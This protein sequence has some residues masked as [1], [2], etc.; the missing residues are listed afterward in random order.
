M[1]KHNRQISRSSKDSAFLTALHRAKE[2]KEKEISRF[3]TPP[4]EYFR[5]GFEVVDQITRG[6]G[7]PYEQIVMIR[8]SSGAGKS[9]FL[10]S[11]ANSL[12]RKE[13]KNVFFISTEANQ[14]LSASILGSTKLDNPGIG[15]IRH[16]SIGRLEEFIEIMEA[17]FKS[18]SDV[19]ILDGL[20]L[21]SNVPMGDRVS[22][23]SLDA[24]GKYAGYQGS[25]LKWIKSSLRGKKKTFLYSTHSRNRS[26][27][28]SLSSS[29]VPGCSSVVLQL[30]EIICSI[31]PPDK[32]SILLNTPLQLRSLAILKNKFGP[33]DTKLPFEFSF[34]KACSCN[35]LL[36]KKGFRLGVIQLKSPWWII[37]TGVNT[38]VKVRGVSEL[39]AWIDENTAVFEELLSQVEQ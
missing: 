8:S 12:I 15:T 26:D 17:F 23:E 37:K 6:L 39:Y 35:E 16:F 19:A 5:T 25:T 27:C 28:R 4:Q 11:L 38:E 9:A 2:R 32:S 36:I 22:T 31:E 34:G 30:S 10:L 14:E 29:E 24:S 13:G 18:S 33:Q 21:L 1:S 3:E 20:D 7:L